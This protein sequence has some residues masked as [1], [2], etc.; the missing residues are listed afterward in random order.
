MLS[1]SVSFHQT[2]LQ[3]VKSEGCPRKKVIALTHRENASECLSVREEQSEHTDHYLVDTPF[4]ANESHL[5]LK[6]GEGV[7][8]VTY[9]TTGEHTLHGQ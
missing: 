1:L 7:Y 6:L 2:V 5:V 4:S 3:N 9:F 8:K